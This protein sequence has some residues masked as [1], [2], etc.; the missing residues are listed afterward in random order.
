MNIHTV[1]TLYQTHYSPLKVLGHQLPPKQPQL[2]QNLLEIE[3]AF[4]VLL[5]D[6]FGVLNVGDQIIPEMPPI[7]RQLQD[8]GKQVFVLTNAGSCASYVT[9]QK[10]PSMGYNIE[11]EY[12][13]SSRDALECA[14][15]SHPLTLHNKL[16]G[17]ITLPEARLADLPARTIYLANDDAFDHV[18]GFLFLGALTW[19]STRQAAL[20]RSLQQ[21]PRPILLGNP[22]MTAPQADQFSVEPGYYTLALADIEGVELTRFGKPFQEV[23]AIAYQRICEV[24]AKHHLP[25]VAKERVLMVGDTL[26]TDILG[27][28]GAGMKTALM[29]DWGFLRG[30]DANVYINQSGITPDF[31]LTQY[32]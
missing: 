5:L 20:I 31:V 2:A 18:D 11:P 13:I 17:A 8:R 30:H 23:Y 21:R 25:Q 28:N 16:W 32:A 27:G 29:T 24:L 26:H 19:N 6:G 7:I 22:D 3:D 4:D 15:K 10:Y 12:V 1:W 9:A 14:L